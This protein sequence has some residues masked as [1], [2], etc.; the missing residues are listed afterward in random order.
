MMERIVEGIERVNYDSALEG[1]NDA[2]EADQRKETMDDLADLDSLVVD[3]PQPRQAVA[4]ESVHA[5][6]D[7]PR[8]TTCLSDFC[9][10]TEFNTGFVSRYCVN[11]Q[12]SGRLSSIF[13]EKLGHKAGQ[14]TL[15]TGFPLRG[16]Q[17]CIST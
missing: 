7:P 3:E 10:S 15:S 17:T 9:R 5:A 11:I 8:E 13:H 16:Q 4:H 2:Q 6:Y 1:N 12:C 14:T